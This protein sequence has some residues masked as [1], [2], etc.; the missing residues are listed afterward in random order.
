MD[1]I[2]LETKSQI[3]ECLQKRNYDE[4]CNFFL[5]KKDRTWIKY[6]RMA[7][8]Y[9]AML[10]Y[11]KEVSNNVENHVLASIKDSEQIIN[12]FRWIRFM[13]LR[14]EFTEEETYDKLYEFAELRGY[15]YYVFEEN[16]KIVVEDSQQQLEKL[17]QCWDRRSLE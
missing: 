7:Y 4:L 1:N 16:L 15:S 8:I 13:F 5:N 2:E 9:V 11:K 3:D 10:I 14:N 17:A 12:D 6:N